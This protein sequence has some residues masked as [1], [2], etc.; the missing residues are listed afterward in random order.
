M[1]PS[2]TKRAYDAVQITADNA[3]AFDGRF[4]ENPPSW[5][6]F[7]LVGLVCVDTDWQ[8][9]VNAGG[10]EWSRAAAPQAVAADNV[11]QNIDLEKALV[12]IPITSSNRS[13]FDLVANVNV[14]TGAAGVCYVCYIG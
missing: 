1:L 11:D 12:M 6:R 2:H 13:N 7:A 5:A 14:T 8:L 10:Q 3:D 4:G 9:S